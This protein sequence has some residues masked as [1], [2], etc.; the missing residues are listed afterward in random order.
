MTLTGL[1]Y[2]TSKENDREQWRR[3]LAEAGLTL[4]DGSFEE[5]ATA[6]SGNDAVWHIAGAQC[7]TWGSG[8]P[9][10]VSPKAT[11][12][13]TG[14]IGLGAWVSVGDASLR[15]ALS[16][17]DG[18]KYVGKASDI[19]ALRNIEPTLT[20]QQIIVDEHTS[21]KKLGGGFF[22]YDSTDTTSLDNNGTVIVTTGGK[23][24]KRVTEG[25]TCVPEWFGAI[26]DG[27][28]DDTVAINAALSSGFKSVQL[29]GKTYKTTGS[30]RIKS[31]GI[32]FYG[33]GPSSVIN[34]FSTTAP[35][36][37]F[38]PILANNQLKDMAILR[39]SVPSNTAHGV[40]VNSS[41]LVNIEGVRC[42]GHYNGFNL[43]PTNSG[44]V[45]RCFASNNIHDG[46][47]LY[48]S[49]TINQMQWKL[50]NN[51]S[52]VNGNNGYTVVTVVGS[53]AGNLGTWTNNDTY[54]NSGYGYVFVGMASSGIYGIRI[55]GGFIGEDGLGEVYLD[56]YGGMHVFKGMF[57]EIPGASKTGPTLTTPASNKGDGFYIT[58]HNRDIS[59][60]NCYISGCKWNGIYSQA[61]GVT[62]VTGCTV[63]NNG[64]ANSAGQRSGILCTAG[65]LIVNGSV[66]GNAQGSTL[67]Q[68]YGV[69]TDTGVTSV[70]LTGNNLL[71][72]AAQ[73]YL[74][75]A[76][77]GAVTQ[78]GNLL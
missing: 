67:T 13:S 54:A 49:A 3:S 71:N 31:S 44:W 19:A 45:S 55:E 51:L 1:T 20:N 21:G 72:N 43:G 25:L 7:Y 62:Q 69:Y 10:D 4:V 12:A 2:N 16:S 17:T 8:F 74:V 75:A 76:G 5:G 35:G 14:G 9:K 30:I 24:W 15:N 11:P 41:D 39:Q 28:T 22:K 37:L 77:T 57:A 40:D 65:K 34:I 26:G 23:R 27:V 50:N 73:A 78:A 38:D 60:L 61:V 53:T 66:I 42:F 58:P 52:Q 63:I 46:F 68:T 36:I 64:Q 47:Y 48:N 32:L 6:Q 56:S 33:V 18:F 59:I 70:A 29:S